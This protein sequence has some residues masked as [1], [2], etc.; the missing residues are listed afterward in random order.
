MLS[1]SAGD[2]AEM[3]VVGFQVFFALATVTAA[4]LIR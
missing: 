2:V 1:D 3:A 4:Y